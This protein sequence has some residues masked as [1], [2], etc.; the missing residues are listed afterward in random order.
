M[1]VLWKHR[2]HGGN[3]S[4]GSIN[5]FAFENV[6]L[7]TGSVVSVFKLYRVTVLQIK[8]KCQTGLYTNKLK[9]LKNLTVYDT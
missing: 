2:L 9:M 7:R 5:S 6:F 1:M 8:Y 4:L 3:S